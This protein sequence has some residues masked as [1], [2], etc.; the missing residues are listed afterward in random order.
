MIL[1]KNLKDTASG[2]RAINKEGMQRLFLLADYAS[3]LESLIQAKMKN[4]GIA[5]IETIPNETKRPSRLVKSIPKY[6]TRSAGIIL[7][8]LIIYRPLQIFFT[9]GVLITLFG[10]LTGI[11]RLILVRQNPDNESLT[12]LLVSIASIIIGSQ[13]IFFGL[14]ARANRANRLIA[15]ETFYRVNKK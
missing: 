3:P 12:L 4:L 13:S 6:V 8:N 15:E 1:G 10:F 14:M 2:F 11:L 5:I 9:T 7:D